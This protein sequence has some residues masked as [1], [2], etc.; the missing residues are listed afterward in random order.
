MCWPSPENRPLRIAPLDASTYQRNAIHGE[1]RIWPEKET[2]RARMELVR[3]LRMTA[4]MPRLRRDDD[5][6]ERFPDV[7]ETLELRLRD[8]SVEPGEEPPARRRT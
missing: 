8:G 4:L 6:Q 1:D 7:A 3:R 2:A 5:E